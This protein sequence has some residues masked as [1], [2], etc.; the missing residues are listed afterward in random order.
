[1]NL[2]SNK[3]MPALF[4]G[5]GSPMNVIEVNRYSNSWK[6]LG[7]CLPEPWAVLSISAH[8]VTRG[9]RIT[10]SESPKTLHDFANF[11]KSLY[12]M[13]YPVPGSPA[14]ARRIQS[15]VTR[16]QV[17]AD[18]NRG[19]DHGTWGLLEPMYP[20]ADIPVLQ[21]S[22]DAGLSPKAHYEIGRQLR[23]LRDEGVLILGSG[24]IVH[25]LGQLDPNPE[26]DPADWA[27]A[28]DDAIEKFLLEGDHTGILGYESLGEAARL[29]VPTPE[30]FL[31][32]LY[33]IA[34]Q[35][36]E[37]RVTFPVEGIAHAGVSMRGV[38]VA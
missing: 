36:K 7:R 8:W 16:T 14:L 35:D 25:N 13:E 1:M 24:N 23:P 33:I 5:H 20:E 30:H 34:L 12:D 3:R 31:P 27:L 11:P 17:E 32:L 19:L 18:F 29:S 6:I 2:T 4:L 26:A 38:M 9:T 37:E 22:L 21:L 15:L 10:A 28:F